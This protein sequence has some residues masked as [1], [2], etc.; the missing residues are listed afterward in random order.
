MVRLLTANEDLRRLAIRHAHLI[1]QLKNATVRRAVGELNVDVFEDLLAQ[2]SQRLENIA[3][4]GFDKGVDTTTRTQQMVRAYE[5]IIDE[6]YKKL[7]V[8]LANHLTETAH[9]EASWQKKAIERAAP[10]ELDVLLPSVKQ[11]ESIVTSRPFQGAILKD[12]FKDLGAKTKTRV[13][14]QLNIGIAQGEPVDVMVRRLKGTKAL[15]YTDGVLNTSRHEIEAVVRTAVQHVQSHA[16]EALFEEN[17]DV[18]DGE[19]WVST[20]DLRTCPACAALDGEVFEIGKGERPPA[21]WNC[22]CTTIPA[23]KSWKELGIDLAEAPE[24]TRASMDG[25]VAGTQTYPEWLKEED[26]R[27]PG[28]ADEVLGPTR[29]ALWRSG[30]VE[31]EDFSNDRNRVLTLEQLSIKEDISIPSRS[32]EKETRLFVKAGAGTSAT[33]KV[34]KGSAKSATGV[35]ESA[36]TQSRA[37]SV[38]QF[39]DAISRSETI[40]D[41]KAAVKRFGAA[42]IRGVKFKN[43]P[44]HYAKQFALTGNRVYRALPGMKAQVEITVEELGDPDAIFGTFRTGFKVRTIAIA[45]KFAENPA[46]LRAVV[47]R[48]FNSGYG[49]T[50]TVD[51]TIAHELGHVMDF[52]NGFFGK[53]RFGK[54]IRSHR[55]TAR[56]LSKYAL[57]SFEELQA[58]A[59]AS[60]MTKSFGEMTKW[61][62][63]AAEELKKDILALG[64]DLPVGLQ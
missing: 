45:P 59:F 43:V 13:T 55:P 14:Q 4:R 7:G 50:G 34:V 15:G 39:E 17:Q 54:Y 36:Q 52:G 12:W 61:E 37:V 10:V 40:A 64:G 26:A 23:L 1:E 8:G 2:L 21:H 27:D 11:L 19:Q 42:E 31:I 51:G 56:D 6:G 24:G 49:A 3:T 38:S 33:D 63:L 29:A 5:T 22:R 30:Q 28:A 46:K 47:S 35:I 41:V 53:S 57:E 32:S 44:V 9:V 58:E 18:V 25:Q 48:L 16:R 60:A 20:L 62:R